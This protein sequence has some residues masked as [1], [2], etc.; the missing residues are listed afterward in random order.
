LNPCKFPPHGIPSVYNSLVLLSAFEVYSLREDQENG[1]Y[2]S[3]MMSEREREGRFA[4]RDE[5]F[6]CK[7][8]QLHVECPVY[9]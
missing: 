1:K 5:G 8:E 2:I 3:S 7:E 6:I 9:K 4:S